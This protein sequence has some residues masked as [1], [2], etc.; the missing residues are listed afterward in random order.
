MLSHGHYAIAHYAALISG[1]LKQ[2]GDTYDATV[3]SA[4]DGTSSLHTGNGMS[5]GSLGQTEKGAE[6]Q[7][8][9]LVMSFRHSPG[10]EAEAE[11]AFVYNSM[12]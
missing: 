4:A 12:R 7:S 6:T 3:H 5:G 10:S 8:R 2:T 1:S 11:S 9:S